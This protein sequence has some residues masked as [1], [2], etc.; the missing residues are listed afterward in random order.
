MTTHTT[1]HRTHQFDAALALALAAAVTGARAE[2]VD[3]RWDTSGRFERSLGVVP[4]K[5][6]EVC[7]KLPAGI[8]VAWSF[9][10]SAPLDFNLHYHVGKDVVYPAKLGA[11]A[12]AKDTLA[13][14]IDQD[15]CW[16]WSNKSTTPATLQLR[17]QR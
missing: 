11:V 4:G 3:I 6:A 7:G 1:P 12:I 2:I 13:T 10:A 5:F 15:Y 14:K 9:E 8:N 16:M 17:L